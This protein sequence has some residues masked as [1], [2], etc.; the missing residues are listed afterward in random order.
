MPFATNLGIQLTENIWGIYL[1]MSHLSI[2]SFQNIFYL[3]HLLNV[4]SIV[5]QFIIVLLT[6]NHILKLAT[7]TLC[8]QKSTTWPIP[9]L[10][11]LTSGTAQVLPKIWHRLQP[12]QQDLCNLE[13]RKHGHDVFP[14]PS[15]SLQMVL[16][17]LGCTYFSFCLFFCIGIYSNI[18]IM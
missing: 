11:Q 1:T 2:Q 9:L 6:R 15:P 12:A 13:L 18:Q 14:R 4:L 17:L 10:E 5:L 16:I 3:I 7:P 8:P